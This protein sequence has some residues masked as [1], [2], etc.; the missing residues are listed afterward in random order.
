VTL[1]KDTGHKHSKQGHLPGTNKR[2]KKFNMEIMDNSLINT[3]SEEQKSGGRPG[4]AWKVQNTVVFQL[5]FRRGMTIIP[6]AEVV[7]VCGHGR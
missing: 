2:L 1:G 4:C 3:T 7:F 5:G 6:T